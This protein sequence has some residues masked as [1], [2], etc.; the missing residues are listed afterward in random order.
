MIGKAGFELTLKMGKVIPV[1]V[2]PHISEQVAQKVKDCKKFKDYVNR[3]EKNPPNVEVSKIEIVGVEMFGER[4]GFVSLRAH[5]KRDGH[6]LPGYVFLRGP[7]I[8]ILMFVNKKLLLVEQF[9]VPLQEV[10]L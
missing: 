9:R 2:L 5:T 3:I 10:M 4:V 1:E 6:S 8:S 7:A